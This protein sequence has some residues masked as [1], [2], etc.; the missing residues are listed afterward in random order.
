ME[1]DAIWKT[2]PGVGPGECIY[3][4]NTRIS[5]MITIDDS[6]GIRT[7]VLACDPGDLIKLMLDFPPGSKADVRMHFQEM[8]LGTE[9]ET[10]VAPEDFP[11]SKRR[12]YGAGRTRVQKHATRPRPR[13]GTGD[14]REDRGE[15]EEEEVKGRPLIEILPEIEDW[16][17]DL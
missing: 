9:E 7:Q 17:K 8:S 13:R 3:R 14:D 1:G 6:R 10:R 12:S 15:K 5:V 16:L 2:G 11:R 4:A